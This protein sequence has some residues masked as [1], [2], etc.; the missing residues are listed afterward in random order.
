MNDNRVRL[1]H[2]EPRITVVSGEMGTGKTLFCL[3]TGYPPERVI[4]FDGEM[5]A[6]QYE[7]RGFHRVDL[8]MLL[9]TKNPNWKP[10][11]LWQAFLE[12]MET[13]EPG[14]YDVIAL[15]PIEDFEAGLTEWVQA[16]PHLFG[17][18]PAQWAQS[19][20]LFWGDVKA[21]EKRILLS[22]AA[23]CQMLLVTAHMRTI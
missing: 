1:N 7:S 14:Q 21:Y 2:N 10:A 3:E 18:T 15:D 11:D 23:K 17:R 12:V 4:L 5:S 6:A 20:G 8:P 16:R 22:L 9:T 19:S 13:V